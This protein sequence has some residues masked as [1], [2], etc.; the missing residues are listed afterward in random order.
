MFCKTRWRWSAHALTRVQDGSAR[1]ER[2]WSILPASCALAPSRLLE[3]LSFLAG[4][5][6]L[7]GSLRVERRVCTPLRAFGG[8]CCDGSVHSLI[9]MTLRAQHNCGSPA[10]TAEWTLEA[11]DPVYTFFTSPVRR[12]IG[13]CLLF[14]ERSL[15]LALQEQ[16]PSEASSNTVQK[17][18]FR[19][20]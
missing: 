5:A 12:S 7:D 1:R 18:S 6:V 4:H 10:H 8:F 13:F 2:R 14:C 20:C 17:T 11:H 3:T 16:S 15:S 19:R 9:L